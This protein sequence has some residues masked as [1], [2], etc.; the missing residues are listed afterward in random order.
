MATT[1]SDGREG[2]TDS[3]SNLLACYDGVTPSSV[4]E[5]TCIKGYNLD[6]DTVAANLSCLVNGLWSSYPRGT[7]TKGMDY[8]IPL[9][10]A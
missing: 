3:V 8:Y 2:V 5:L 4:A 9:D 6:S 7:C 1:C 10:H